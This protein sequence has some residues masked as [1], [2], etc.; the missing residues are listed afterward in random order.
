METWFGGETDYG[1]CR[2]QKVLVLEKGKREW[3]SQ[4]C[5]QGE[6]F[7]SYW[8]EKQEG[9]IFV[10]FCNYQ[11]SNANILQVGRFDWDTPES[12]L[13]SWKEDRQATS[14]QMPGS[15]DL[16]R[17]RRTNCSLLLEHM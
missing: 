17:H 15:E 16:L 12:A 10:N 11:G 7:L 13:Y 9:L 14:E 6:H 3:N 8:L 1:S 5:T 4:R 2:K